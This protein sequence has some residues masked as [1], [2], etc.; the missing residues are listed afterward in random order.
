[1]L[2]NIV[3]FKSLKTATLE[4]LVYNLSQ[5]FFEEGQIIF[6]HGDHLDK[7]Y[8]LADGSIDAFLSLHDEDLV[9]DN[10]KIS[11]SILGQYSLISNSSINFSARATSETNML[12]ISLE[13]L[14]KVRADNIELNYLIKELALNLQEKGNHMLDYTCIRK[15]PG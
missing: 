5:E 2:L 12:V 8:V 1:M 6:K 13:T 9:L 11:G 7:V 15:K 14:N 3:Y 10:L 4:I